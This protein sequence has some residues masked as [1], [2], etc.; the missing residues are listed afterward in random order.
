MSLES[1]VVK[2]ETEHRLVTCNIDRQLGE[3]KVVCVELRSDMSVL[4]REFA[5]RPL[6]C[7]TAV[8]GKIEKVKEEAR[9]S[10]NRAIKMWMGGFGLVLTLVAIAVAVVQANH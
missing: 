3:I 2:L 1:R 4:R 10:S 9:M 8:N 5:E 6:K 7:M